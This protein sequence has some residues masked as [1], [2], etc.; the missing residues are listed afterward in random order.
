MAARRS[1][2]ASIVGGRLF[3]SISRRQSWATMSR[4]GPLMSVMAKVVSA[5]S[6]TARTSRI[7]R[8][9]NPMEPAPIIAIL[10]GMLVLLAWI[11]LMQNARETVAPDFD[12]LWDYSQPEA[13]EKKF[14]EILPVAEKSGDV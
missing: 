3:A 2:L 13:T 14:A 8:R 5:S 4:F 11:V 9:V 7:S 6:G 10:M 12:K 1:V